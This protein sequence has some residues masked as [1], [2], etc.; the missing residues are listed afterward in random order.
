MRRE[1]LKMLRC[2]DVLEQKKFMDGHADIQLVLD[3]LDML[4]WQ[5]EIYLKYTQFKESKHGN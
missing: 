2:L 3:Y 1:L 5:C 4:K